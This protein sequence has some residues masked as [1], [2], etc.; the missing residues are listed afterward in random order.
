MPKRQE[1]KHKDGAQKAYFGLYIFSLST[2]CVYHL[3]EDGSLI[4]KPIAAVSESSDRSRTATLKCIDFVIKEVDKQVALM[5]MDAQLHYDLGSDSKLHPTYRTD[6]L[7]DWHNNKAHYDK[8]PMAGIGGAFKKGH[9]F[10]I[11]F[12]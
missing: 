8:G 11:A 7:I 10:S 9:Q 3:D 12:L 5:K 4:K 2:A 6:L 1:Q